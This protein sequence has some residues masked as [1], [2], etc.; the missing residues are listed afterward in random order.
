MKKTNLGKR[1]QVYRSFKDVAIQFASDVETMGKKFSNLIVAYFDPANPWDQS[2]MV[3]IMT[4][5]LAFA[6]VW[7]E[8]GGDNLEKLMKELYE[9]NLKEYRKQLVKKQ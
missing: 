6:E 7:A 5:I 4:N 3:A 8:L 1:V 2:V 9:D